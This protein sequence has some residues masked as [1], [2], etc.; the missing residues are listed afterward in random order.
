MP[1]RCQFAPN[2]N[3]MSPVTKQNPESEQTALPRAHAHLRNRPVSMRT[4]HPRPQGEAHALLVCA[5]AKAAHGLFRFGL[6]AGLAGPDT[7]A[8]AAQAE[9]VTALLWYP[10]GTTA[11][12]LRIG[13]R[14][15]KGLVELGQDLLASALERS[16]RDELLEGWSK[17]GPGAAGRDP[18]HHQRRPRRHGAGVTAGR[19]HPGRGTAE[20]IRTG[21]GCRRSRHRYPDCGR[22]RHRRP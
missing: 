15:S 1:C 17:D 19:S 13:V 22:G 10:S 14:G 20:T 3:G 4:K 21:T 11:G 8:P 18:G 12:Y 2:P 7:A 5:C 6:P 9:A 16:G